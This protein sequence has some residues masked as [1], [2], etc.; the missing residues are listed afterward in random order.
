MDQPKLTNVYS[1]NKN[2]KIILVLNSVCSDWQSLHDC[3]LI[4]KTQ[5]LK[6]SIIN[7]RLFHTRFDLRLVDENQIST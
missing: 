2:Q 3:V 4:H 1:Y 6:F 5:K 7:F